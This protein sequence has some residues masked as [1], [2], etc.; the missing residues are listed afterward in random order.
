[1]YIDNGKILECGTH[2]E[3]MKLKGAYYKL[4]MSQYLY[5]DAV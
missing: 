5:L 2:D 1:M 4:F 3:L